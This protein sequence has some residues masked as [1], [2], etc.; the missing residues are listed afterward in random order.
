[1]TGAE[2]ASN[3]IALIAFVV[4]SFSLYYTSCEGPRLRIGIAQQAFLNAKPRIGLLT[5]VQNDGAKAGTFISG[6]LLWDSIDL[7]MVMTSPHL[8][9]WTYTDK[10]T[11]KEVDKTTFT[12][13]YPVQIQGHSS[14]AATLWFS[15]DEG[16][17]DR[18]FT[19]GEHVLEVRL[20]DGVTNEPI[21]IRR[22]GL[23]LE[24]QQIADIYGRGSETTEFAIP[25]TFNN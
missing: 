7:R 11:M 22:F 16:Q 15:R 24:P 4:S 2:K 19:S 3:S 8:D 1:M 21:V 20:Y 14:Q 18:L 13:I 10:G 25:L 23:K 17:G 9:S 6:R 5:N 12:F